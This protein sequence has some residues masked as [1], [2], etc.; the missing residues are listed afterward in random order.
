MISEFILQSHY[1]LN[2]KNKE[3]TKK[4]RKSYLCIISSRAIKSTD[5]LIMNA[6]LLVKTEKSNGVSEGLVKANRRYRQLKMAD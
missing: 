5:V 3:T 6:V 2:T 1:H 4:K